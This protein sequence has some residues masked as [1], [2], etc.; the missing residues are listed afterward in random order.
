MEEVKVANVTMSAS[1]VKGPYLYIIVS[2]DWP[3]SDE[4]WLAAF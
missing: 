3:L 1:S 2:R 4:R